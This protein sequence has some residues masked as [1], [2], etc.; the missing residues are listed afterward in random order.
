MRRH[1]TANQTPRVARLRRELTLAALATRVGISTSYLS[2]LERGDISPS[3]WIRR[4]WEQALG[5]SW[6]DPKPLAATPSS[7]SDSQ[8]RLGLSLRSSTNWIDGLLPAETLIESGPPPTFAWDI[9]QT[10]PQL[11]YLTHNYFRYYG[12]FPPT[13]PRKLLRDF[14]PKPGTW[15]LDNFSGCGTTLVEAKCEGIPSIGV[16][17]SPLATLASQVKTTYL[18]AHVIMDGASA[19]IKAARQKSKPAGVS[20]EKWFVAATAADLTRLKR[21]ILDLKPGPLRSLLVLAFLAIIRRVSNAYDGEVRPHVN[22]A[23]RTRDVFDAFAKKTVDMVERMEKFGSEAQPVPAI[24]ITADNRRLAELTD[25]ERKPIGLV[26]SH[27]PYLNCFDYAPVYR[28]EYVWAD[29][30]SELGEDFD[31]ERLRRSETK[32][33]PATDDRIF[34]RY[35]EDLATA[36]GEVAALLEP[37]TF[38]AVV[39]GDCTIR[40]RVIPVLDRFR[41]LMGDIGFEL[42]RTFLRSTHYGIGKYAYADRADYHGTAKKRDGVLLFKRRARSTARPARPGT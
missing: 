15:V 6:L 34:D 19:V 28:L 38:C 4:N 14:R 8:L 25:L 21:S 26:I 31:Y 36:Y 22:G 32:C 37:G 3:D 27:P 35:F 33:W 41:D 18:P 17:I 24:A 30:F 39:L 40:G 10:I 23:K 12:K 29:G 20:D 1:P 2:K 7:S 16:D 9:P 13:I 11:S 5:T 42:D